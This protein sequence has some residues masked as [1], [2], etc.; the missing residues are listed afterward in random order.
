MSIYKNE[1]K[2]TQVVTLKD[3]VVSV[4]AGGTFEAKPEEVTMKLLNLIFGGK[5]REEIKK[6]V[7]FSKPDGTENIPEDV[8]SSDP[9]IVT[10]AEE[11]LID[12]AEKEDTENSD[13]LTTEGETEHSVMEGYKALTGSENKQRNAPKN[14]RRN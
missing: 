10:I 7:V 1:T 5:I 3:R 13:S 12:S 11:S 4:I 9:E 2:T 6:D 8:G 14:R